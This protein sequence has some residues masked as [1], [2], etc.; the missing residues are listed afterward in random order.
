MYSIRVSSCGMSYLMNNHLSFSTK[1]KLN[2]LS[3]EQ[4]ILQ[5]VHPVLFSSSN[6]G[7]RQIEIYYSSDCV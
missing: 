2:V 3:Q 6:S 4:N 5:W 1:L 7:P